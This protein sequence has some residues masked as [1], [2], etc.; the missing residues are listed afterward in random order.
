VVSVRVLGVNYCATGYFN[1]TSGSC[2]PNPVV[3]AERSLASVSLLQGSGTKSQVAGDAVQVKVIPLDRFGNQV[4]FEHS[5]TELKY[6]LNVTMLNSLNPGVPNGTVYVRNRPLAFNI[7]DNSHQ[8]SYILTSAG[9]YLLAV[10]MLDPRWYLEQTY[11]VTRKAIAL[12]V[13]SSVVDVL[14]TQVITPN[15]TASAQYA[16][17]ILARD[18]YGNLVKSDLTDSMVV[19]IVGPLTLSSVDGLV[20]IERNADATYDAFFQTP[21]AGLYQVQNR[22]VA[23]HSVG[24][25]YRICAS[26]GIPLVTRS[27]CA[28]CPG[29]RWRRVTNRRIVRYSIGDEKRLCASLRIPL[30]TRRECAHRPAFYF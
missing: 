4:T 20:I 10:D 1:A 25:T 26:S 13:G 24:D 19:N 30:V 21:S 28:H 2:I 5:F 6:S 22:L 17:K 29:F 12:T 15:A 9:D 23:Y 16:V 8:A 14:T 18:R 27:E 11:L 3:T 7:Q